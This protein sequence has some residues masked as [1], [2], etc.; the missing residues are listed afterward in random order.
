MTS[1]SDVSSILAVDIGSCKTSAAL[2]DL[3]E[4]QHRFVARADTLTTQFWPIEDVSVGVRRTVEKI[5]R[6][7]GRKIMSPSG[8]ILPERT[9]GSGVDSFVTAAS[10]GGSLRLL[11]ITPSIGLP[12]FRQLQGAA[13]SRGCEMEVM[14]V[15]GLDG[16][17]EARAGT[18]AKGLRSF[19]P[20]AVFLFGQSGGKAA[21][22]ALVKLGQDA[23]DA[24]TSESHERLPVR[25]VGE[26]E[27]GT[28][29]AREIGEVLDFAALS[30]R[31]AAGDEAFR[32]LDHALVDLWRQFV[33]GRVPGYNVVAA[34]QK[35][36]AEHSSFALGD[37][38]RFLAGYH[39]VEVLAVDIGASSV[40]LFKITKD[41]EQIALTARYGVGRNA[42]V[43]LNG[44]GK[45]EGQ[46]LAEN[47]SLK[48][49]LPMDPTPE[50]LATAVLNKW[51]R[52]WT[53]PETAEEMLFERALGVESVHRLRAELRDEP[54]LFS[55]R[56]KEGLG[57]AVGGGST[58]A[59]QN[60]LGRMALTLL[61]ALEPAGAFELAIDRDAM[62]AHL[63]MVGRVCS[64]AAA[65][66]L[67]G[68]VLLRL[69]T[70]ISCS[71]QGRAGSRAASIEMT[72]RGQVEKLQIGFDEILA[73]PLPLGETAELL[74]KPG[75]GLDFGWGKGK[76]GKLTVKGGALGLV[77]DARGR[78]VAEADRRR[79][80]KTRQ[81]LEALERQEAV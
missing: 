50:E 4:G 35:A 29:L 79:S 36:P 41:G 31:E 8:P 16:G 62:L 25:F 49:W 53:T 74:V 37:S 55:I 21:A 20:H 70:C 19:Q 61:D 69:G 65:E 11:V 45:A 71:G 32:A 57:V 30:P 14:T 38:L 67:V 75:N 15:D 63:G 28:S 27:V 56:E 42:A 60:S 58:I 18:I 6:I 3:V 77:I 7:C 13:A 43:L 68:D 39:K 59:N 54:Y 46:P 66:V 81:W 12:S 33:L 76:S 22:N 64:T 73:V 34:W 2:F 80:E 48:R 26:A 78:P 9:D 10:V 44:D 23:A 24:I 40:G 17:S 1:R 51:A 5:E 72:H 47:I 52:P